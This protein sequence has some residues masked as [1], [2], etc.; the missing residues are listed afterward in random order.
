LLGL[1]TTVVACGGASATV[2]GKAVLDASDRSGFQTSTGD[3]VHKEAAKSFDDAIKSF[4]AH[5]KAF[6]WNEGTCKE[7]ATMFT[8]ASDVQQSAT[9]RA[10]PSALYNAG[11]SF[12][13]CELQSEA[14]HQ[15]QAALEAD[16]NFHR[17]AT[18]LALYEFQ[19]NQNLDSTIDKLNQIIRD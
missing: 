16:R 5:D 4:V 9:R 19:K 6:D 15:F 14:Q 3:Q 17:A 12:Q 10:F 18:Q 8:K 11:L 13:R 1:M 7:V 2:G